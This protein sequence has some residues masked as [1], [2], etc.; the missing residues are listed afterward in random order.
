VDKGFCLKKYTGPSRA[1]VPHTKEIH[2]GS[3]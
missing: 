3:S 2:D 1:G